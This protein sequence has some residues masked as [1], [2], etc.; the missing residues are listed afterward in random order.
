M[1][2]RFAV[3][4]LAAAL[5]AAVPA[6]AIG[7]DA[8]RYAGRRLDDV[9]RLLQEK[10]ARIIFASSLVPPTLRVKVEPVTR[11]L[12]EVAEEVLAPHGLALKDGPAGTWIVVPRP[13]AAPAANRPAEPRA[14]QKPRVTPQ[15]IPPE[16][17]LRI[18]EQVDVTERPRE[19]A[20]APAVYTMAASN[21]LETAGGLENVF[22]VLPLLPGVAATNDEEGKLAVRGAGPEH[23]VVLFDGAQ[24]HSPQRIGDFGTSFVNPAT[25]ASVALD[26]SGLD[27]RYGGRLSSMT[28]LETRDGRIDRRFAVSGA[29]GLTSGDIVVEGRVPGT[30]SASWWATARGTYY[31]FV[32]DRFQD[33]DI[34]SFTDLQVKMTSYPTDRT[35]LTVSGLVGREKMFRP[36][37]GPGSDA[38]V[39]N[40]LKEFDAD[41]RLA[42]A[43]LLWTPGPRVTAASTL[44]L[45]SNDSRYQH[46]YNRPGAGP[47]GR[48]VRVADFAARQRVSLTVSRR[49]TV[50][51]GLEVRRLRSQW[52]MTG[53][54]FPP[55]LRTVGPSTWGRLIE[56]D[57]PI[58]SEIVK[59]QTGAWIQDRASIGAGLFVEPGLRVDWNSLTGETAVQPR[60]RLAKTVG[61]G[62]I[63]AGIAWQ[64]QTPG[65]ETMQQGHQY[66][67]L[68]GPEQSALRN[69]RSRQIVFGAE[70]PISRSM[71]IRVEAYRRRFDRLLQQRQENQGEYERRLARYDIP[72]D[73]PPDDALLEYRPTIHPDSTGTGRGAGLELLLQRTHGRVFGW[74]SYVWSKSERELY[75]HTVPFDF[76]R[77]HAAAIAVNVQVV[78]RVRV[79]ATSQY[80]SGFPIAPL[81]PEVQF[82]QVP[83]PSSGLLRPLRDGEGNLLERRYPDNLV[84]LGLV[85]SSRLPPYARTDVR[86]TVA[87]T[88]W[89]EAY[90]EILN[91][92]NRSNFRAKE[93]I[94]GEPGFDAGYQAEPSFPRL[95]SYGVRVMF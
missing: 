23:N 95:P 59:T 21:V 55:S 64:A 9:L 51:T 49:H 60:L 1:R 72:P 30:R 70:Y 54:I 86:V 76:D 14:P 24:V 42:V 61:R 33:G 44:S 22:Q 71:T 66:Y 63:W 27:A 38:F 3:S 80:A 85:N 7:Q 81:H 53:W 57:G 16:Q 56:Y 8:T 41:N 46:H 79:S 65:H 37:V 50:D 92:F 88:K 89:L 2:L 84:R 31:K 20:P 12:R 4:V 45:Y 77:P 75:G 78:S 67:D 48:D 11:S 25:T 17:P 69:E 43:N 94:G 68:T 39:N 35:R 40:T 5:A 18:E 62:S 58:D 90:G 32:A 91:L 74:V 6:T 19:P 13:A 28:L 36:I 10:G 47:F 15:E 52:G 87:I 73:M 34:P 26:A 29:V 93:R 82:S 83:S